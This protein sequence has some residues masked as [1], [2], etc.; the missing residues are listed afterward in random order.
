MRQC[1][2]LICVI[3]VFFF[4]SIFAATQFE[5]LRARRAFPCFDEPALKATFNVTLVHDPKLISL[6]NMPLYQTYE[7]EGLKYDRFKKSVKM[8]TYLV[9]FFVGDFK[10]K[11]TETDTGV[12]VRLHPFFVLFLFAFV[13]LFCFFICQAELKKNKNETSENARTDSQ[14][15]A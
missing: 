3:I 12:K 5:P 1:F 7:K 13:V 10:F 11:E 6:S 14:K 15:G 8:S 4:S 9:A 2:N